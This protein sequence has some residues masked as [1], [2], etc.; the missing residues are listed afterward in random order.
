M[1]L[2]LD[3]FGS[4]AALESSLSKLDDSP[5]SSPKTA[6][7]FIDHAWYTERNKRGRRMDLIGDYAG[8]ERFILDGTY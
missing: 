6:L 5:S 3:D 8:S 4:D 1:D 7:K 2:D